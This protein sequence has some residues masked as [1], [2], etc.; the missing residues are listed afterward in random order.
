M[1]L[2]TRFVKNVGQRHS[3]STWD[4]DLLVKPLGG[5]LLGLYGHNKGSD[6]YV[7]LFDSTTAVSDGTSP[8]IHPIFISGSDNF[9]MEVPVRGMRFS[10]GLYVANSTT[11]TTL[12]IGS[13]D[14]WFTVVMI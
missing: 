5:V 9:F 2:S 13:A 10:N 11:N 8:S 12:T 3:N 7:M 6:Q 4:N 14:C 1:S